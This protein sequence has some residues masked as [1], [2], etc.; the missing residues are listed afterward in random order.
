MGNAGSCAPSIISSHSAVKVLMSDGRLGIFSRP[1]T[2]A[3]LMLANP[4]QFVCDSGHL[5]VGHRIP[6]LLADEELEPNGQLYY[7]LPIELLYSV[8]TSEEMSCFN[9]QASRALKHGI[10]KLSRIFPVLV[11]FRLLRN[12]SSKN[13]LENEVIREEENNNDTFLPQKSWRPALETIVE[14]PPR[15]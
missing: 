1:V 4:G 13:R 2:A 12:S 11:D 5:K 9:E 7:L 3:E 10:L 8:L 14:T 6:G 15:P